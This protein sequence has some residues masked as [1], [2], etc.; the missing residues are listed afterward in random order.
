MKASR[1]L[2]YALGPV[3][4]GIFSIVSV[5]LMAHLFDVEDI[6]RLSV[7]LVA[8]N[9]STLFF[10]LG[11]DQAFVREFHEYENKASLLVTATIPG[12]FLLGA[13][14]IALM[15]AD[16][17]LFSRLLFDKHAA[18]VSAI[19]FA[20]LIFSYLSRFL[21]LLLRMQERAIAYSF[22]QLLSKALLLAIV[23][24]YL[25]LEPPYTLLMLLSAQAAALALTLLV[26]AWN[27][28]RHW[29]INLAKAFDAQIFS[30]LFKYGAPLILAGLISWGV[31][32]IGT[33]SLRV[34]S[35]Y[36]QLGIFSVA[37][38][39][40]AVVTILA[41][42]FN[43]IWAPLVFKW[44]SAGVDLVRVNVIARQLMVVIGI[45]T[46]FAGSIGWTLSYILPL[47]YKP[48]MTIFTGCILAPMFY[49]LSEVTGIGI[50][51][52]KKTKYAV[53]VA[54]AS[55]IF[56]A[57][58]AAVLVPLFGALGAMYSNLGAFWLFFVLRTEVS[59]RFLN[60]MP[61]QRIYIDS[62]ALTAF[63]AI[64]STVSAAGFLQISG[65][66]AVV[67]GV[68]YFFISRDIV[69]LI[70][71]QFTESKLSAKR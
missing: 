6:G 23:G 14:G 5:P 70:I 32:S 59:A 56:G 19:F 8:I 39:F 7:L 34:L 15:L 9:F 66:L 69:I 62:A 57:L 16:D 42:V 29:C 60:A 54:L 61:R 43:T 44:H 35:D 28:R 25:L 63:V 27:T 68:V 49:T 30:S 50:A 3:G 11:L 52:S 24:A 31:N 33:L 21:S 1:I 36:R 46:C 47:E 4:G 48:V 41:S 67:F 65:L 40:A 12:L 37:T 2:A 20:C 10:C 17:E 51:I 71:R 22:S 13:V 58:L 18:S 55:L 53:Y 45:L 64:Y 26:F 38:S